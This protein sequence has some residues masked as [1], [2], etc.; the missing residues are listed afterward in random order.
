MKGMKS[1]KKLAVAVLVAGS[2]GTLSAPALAAPGLVTVCWPISYKVGPV[3][4][5]IKVQF[6]VT[7]ATFQSTYAPKGAFLGTC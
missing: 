3:T 2:L 1:M 7:L 4:K 6:P 5:T